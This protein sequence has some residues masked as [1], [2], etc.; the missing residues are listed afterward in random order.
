MNARWKIQVWMVQRKSRFLNL[1]RGDGTTQEFVSGGFRVWKFQSFRLATEYFISANSR[2]CSHISFVQTVEDKRILCCVLNYLVER[3]F[4]MRLLPRLLPRDRHA[5]ASLRDRT[6][7][8]R[9]LFLFW[10]RFAQLT[11]GGTTLRATWRSSKKCD[12][13]ETSSF[14][15]A[16]GS[17]CFF[18]TSTFPA[19]KHHQPCTLLQSAS[20]LQL[21]I[22]AFGK[23]KLPKLLGPKTFCESIFSSGFSESTHGG[24]ATVPHSCLRVGLPMPSAWAFRRRSP[25]IPRENTAFRLRAKSWQWKILPDAAWVQE[26]K[27]ASFEN[28][29]SGYGFINITAESAF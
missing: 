13:H 2:S 16:F 20:Q 22:G 19:L 23:T 6:W 11:V 8:K 4:R 21:S 18:L 29:I 15:V 12:N 7:M 27:F 10:S 28:T 26:W 9:V 25:H 24:V 17:F 1:K 14:C 3:E 5:G